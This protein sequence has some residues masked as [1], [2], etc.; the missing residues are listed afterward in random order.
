[1]Y[2]FIHVSGST[3]YDWK[4][5]PTYIFLAKCLWNNALVDLI[6]YGTFTTIVIAPSASGPDYFPSMKYMF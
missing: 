4:D 6:S 1:M 3:R 5:R 2:G